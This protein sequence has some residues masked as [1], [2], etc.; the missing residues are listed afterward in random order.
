M[1]TAFLPDYAI[2]PGETLEETIQALG[3]TQAQLAELT[4]RP[5]NTISEIIS[6]KAAITPET[7]LQLERVLG[8]TASFWYN[9]EANYV[10]TL[11]R[12]RGR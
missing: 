6:G 3:M 1:R 11:A 4:G 12:L 10:Q 7:A 8:V 5:Q 9:L 2:P